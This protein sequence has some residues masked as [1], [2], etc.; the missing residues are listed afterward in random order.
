MRCCGAYNP[1]RSSST[2]YDA[3]KN[4]FIGGSQSGGREVFIN[5]STPAST[6]CIM[7]NLKQAE[8]ILSRD[9]KY[10]VKGAHF[11]GTYANPRVGGTLP[12]VV[13]DVE[14]YE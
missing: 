8:I 9:T 3:K 6:N 2:A 4:P 5:I 10:R 11:D 13:V 14:I 7:G 12:R 1:R